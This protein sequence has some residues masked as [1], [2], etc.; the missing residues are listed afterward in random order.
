MVS[1]TAPHAA[2]LPGG[3]GPAGRG[4]GDARA[5][6]PRHEIPCAAA[7]MRPSRSRPHRVEPPP[8]RSALVA[9][10]A[11][12]PPPWPCPRA[13]VGAAQPEPHRSRRERPT[14]RRR[15]DRVLIGPE[16]L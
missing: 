12:E 13:G 5:S 4:L 7:A 15:R 11:L 1:G 8:P 3:G 10:E 14:R 6:A 16:H 9:L 2:L